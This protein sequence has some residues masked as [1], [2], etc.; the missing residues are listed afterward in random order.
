MA[1]AAEVAEGPEGPEVSDAPEAAEASEASPVLVVRGDTYERRNR[2]K[3]RSALHPAN[4][5]PIAPVPA[6][7]LSVFTFITPPS[8]ALPVAVIPAVSVL[9]VEGDRGEQR[10]R[11]CG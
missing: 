7:F 5:R 10:N 2:L 8:A 4:I 1:E 11:C 3:H 9:P 6:Q